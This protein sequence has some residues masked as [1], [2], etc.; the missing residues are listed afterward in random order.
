M[1]SNNPLMSVSANEIWIYSKC[2][3]HSL[4]KLTLWCLFPINHRNN[5]S[6]IISSFRTLGLVPMVRGTVQR[7]LFIFTAVCTDQSGR[8]GLFHC[9][10]CEYDPCLTSTKEHITFL[11]GLSDFVVSA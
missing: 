4:P 5:E 11:S 6:F 10:L 3:T 1:Y 2:D 9:I 8:L 7:T